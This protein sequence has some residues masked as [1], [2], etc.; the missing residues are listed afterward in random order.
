MEKTPKTLFNRF[1]GWTAALLASLVAVFM[2]IFP[3]TPT[4]FLDSGS[5]E[6]TKKT[7]KRP[8]PAES[9]VRMRGVSLALPARP[10]DEVKKAPKA[11][12]GTVDTKPA[13]QADDALLLEALNE[14]IEL[15]DGGDWQAAEE[16]LLEILKTSPDNESA[17]V[18]M[19]MIHLLDKKDPNGALPYME[20]ALR[21]NASNES[22]ISELIS[23]YDSQGRAGQAVE[24]LK[25]LARQQPQSEEIDYGLAQAMVMT[26]RPAEAIEYL[27][28][29]A[30]AKT[31]WD[32]DDVMEQLG[33]T[34]AE[35]GQSEQALESWREVI[36]RQKAYMEA[37][38]EQHS[39]LKEQHMTIKLKYAS[40]LLESGQFDRASKVIEELERELPNDDWVASLKKAAE[41]RAL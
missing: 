2:V 6:L 5:L 40:A 11:P 13:P 3:K 10:K 26:G 33:D 29:S 41:A 12:L 23:V 15:V 35:L 25:D 14:A 37:D 22:M 39:H 18:E 7:Q 20:K 28:R 1:L 27:Q 36:D 24:F 16:M 4:D 30:D 21:L 32:R 17:L 9:Q 19:A 8:R 38:P 34:Y 31:G